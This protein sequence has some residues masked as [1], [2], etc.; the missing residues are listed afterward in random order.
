MSQIEELQSRI[1]LAMARIDAGVSQLAE[2]T[3]DTAPGPD[4]AAALEEERRASAH[5]ED[6]LRALRAE[7][8]DEIAALRADLDR[9]TEI[10]ALKDQIAEYDQAVEQLDMD[11]QRLREANEQLRNSNAA[12]RTANENGVGKPRLINKAMLAEL[13]ALRATRATE[14]AEVGVILARLKP[15]LGDADGAAETEDM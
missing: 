3:S 9:A 7:H 2:Q 5:L 15:L 11:L 4:L 1:T 8:D 13:E 10:E 14:V 6:R 12:L